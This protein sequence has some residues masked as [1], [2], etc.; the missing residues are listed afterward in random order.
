MRKWIPAFMLLAV[1]GS[2]TSVF[3]HNEEHVEKTFRFRRDKTLQVRLDVDAGEVQVIKGSTESEGKVLIDYDE[4]QF[5]AEVRFDEDLP[6]LRVKLSKRR[7][8]RGGDGAAD[9]TV[10]LPTEVP[11]EFDGR[12]KAGEVQM[13]VGGL[14]L[15]AFSLSVWAG[16]TTVR[17]EEPNKTEMDFLQIHPKVG[18][19]RLISLGNARFREADINAGVGELTADFGGEVEPRGRVEVDLDIGATHIILP[20]DTAVKFSISKCLFLSEVQV[21]HAFRKSGRYYYSPNYEEPSEALV[22]RIHPGMGELA[23]RQE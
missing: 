20:R 15:R 9:V 2:N 1:L 10:E 12:V 13:R 14:M 4:D 18:E 5:E 23:I 16:E 3:A 19:A 21:P 11:I 17:F 7:W 22:L 8:F 6:L